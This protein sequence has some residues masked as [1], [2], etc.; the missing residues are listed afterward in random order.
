VA[1]GYIEFAERKP[2]PEFAHLPVVF[3]PFKS[4]VAVEFSSDLRI[5][6]QPWGGGSAFPTVHAVACG[7]QG[8]RSAGITIDV[9]PCPFVKRMACQ[10]LLVHESLGV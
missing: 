3:A 1:G 10:I 4:L 2:L 9:M 5:G 6:K 8:A 7:C